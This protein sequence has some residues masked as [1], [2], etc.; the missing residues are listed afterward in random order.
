MRPSQQHGTH[1]TKVRSTVECI[2]NIQYILWIL[3]RREETFT[4]QIG[5]DALV[6]TVQPT[7][8]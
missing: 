3:Q 6:N 5:L 7:V 8:C 1:T 2:P 4:V